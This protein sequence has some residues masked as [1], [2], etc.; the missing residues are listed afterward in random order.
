MLGN[1]MASFTFA[2]KNN[3]L[4]DYVGNYAS[5]NEFDITFDNRELTVDAENVKI[6]AK[7]SK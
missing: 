3:V 2:L 4:E 1:T 7:G 5:G 6:E